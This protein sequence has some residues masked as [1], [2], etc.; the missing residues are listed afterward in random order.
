MNAAIGF[1]IVAAVAYGASDFVGGL[2]SRQVSAWKIAFTGQL[3]GAAVIAILAAITVQGAPTLADFAW[4][5]LGGVG[6]ACGSAFLYRGLASGRMGLVAPVSAVGAAMLPL[7]IGVLTGDRPSPIVWLG[8]LAAL[9]GIWLVSRSS[10]HGAGRERDLAAIGDGVLAGLGFGVLFV[11]V[12]QVPASAGAWPLTVQN[13][14]GAIATIV[15]SVLL[16]QPWL[17][18]EPR[19]WGGVSAGAVGALG[20]ASFLAATHHGNLSVAG[21]L[22]STYPVF[23]VALAALVLRERVV[24]GQAWGMALCITSV[25]LVAAG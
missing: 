14:V 10:G 5:A 8:V 25:A 3:G 9:P 17:P 12:G 22:A 20:T 11:A 4:A 21:V 18:R 19:D 2:S 1:A 15:G 24:H 16:R 23:T 6:G 13:V 7:A